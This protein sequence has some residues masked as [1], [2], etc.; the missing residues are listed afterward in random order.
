MTLSVNDDLYTPIL[1]AI[2]LM[3]G[4]PCADVCAPL[5][6]VAS[7]VPGPPL[8]LHN[9]WMDRCHVRQARIPTSLLGCS[10]SDC[11]ERSRSAR[12]SRILCALSKWKV[13]C[14]GSVARFT[15]AEASPPRWLASSRLSSD[16]HPR[17][18]MSS[19]YD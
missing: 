2:A 19:I 14:L 16:A 3:T 10:V 13:R 7:P 6:A 4:V 12:N 15:I 9:R 8:S 18:S 5:F 11:R 1:S 17:M